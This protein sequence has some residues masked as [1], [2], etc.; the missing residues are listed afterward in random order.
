MATE[1]G[2]KYEWYVLAEKWG[3]TW[4]QLTDYDGEPLEFRD[5]QEA[6]SE[7]EE[8]VRERED[9]GETNKL[10]IFKETREIVVEATPKGKEE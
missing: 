9:L 3:N 1:L 6:V 7:F 2:V 8:I 10:W 5:F 4:N